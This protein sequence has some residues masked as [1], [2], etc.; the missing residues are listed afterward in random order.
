[1][2]S[3][4]AALFRTSGASQRISCP[5]AQPDPV[6]ALGFV[7]IGGCHQNSDS[8]LEQLIKDRPEVAA[9]NGVDSIGGLIEKQDLWAVQQR[10]HQRKF[11]FHSAGEL[12][13]LPF[14]KWLHAGHPQQPRRE[15]CTFRPD[16]SEQIRIKIHVFLDR[17]IKVQPE[18]LGH[19][20][21]PVLDAWGRA[22]R[23]VGDA[24]LLRSVNSPQSA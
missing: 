13:G 6:A 10:A 3:T 1:M 18:F 20:P 7:E 4:A 11:L 16:N 2:E 22:P 12:P 15:L 14:A 24:G 23:R 5:D 8:I 21:D 17:K 9:R 19:I